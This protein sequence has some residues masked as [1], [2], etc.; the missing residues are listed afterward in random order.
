MKIDKGLI[1]SEIKSHYGLKTDA[2]FARFLGIKPQTLASWY[3]RNSF[4]IELL[5]AKCV[6][7]EP[8]WLLSGSGHML[9]NNISN[10][11]DAHLSNTSKIVQNQCKD[12]KKNSHLQENITIVDNLLER[13]ENLSKE[14]GHLEAENEHL[15]SQLAEK[16]IMLENVL[17]ADAG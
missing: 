16:N 17:R 8:D 5:Y 3:T 10:S 15:R 9:R 7:I 14:N 4:D 6:D 1:L 2:D 12:T 11:S 13:L